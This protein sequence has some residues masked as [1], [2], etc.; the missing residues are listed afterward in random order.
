MLS[1]VEPSRVAF[2]QLPQRER[3]G[4]LL[5]HPSTGEVAFLATTGELELSGEPLAW[6]EVLRCQVGETELPLE[7]CLDAWL[8]PGIGARRLLSGRADL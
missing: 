2:F 5:N 4:V 6:R 1:V 3:L 8:E 7:V